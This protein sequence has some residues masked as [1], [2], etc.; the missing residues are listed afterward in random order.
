MTT[1]VN[2]QVQEQE[3]T[4][5][6]VA[7]GAKRWVLFEPEVSKKFVK[8]KDHKL[9]HEDDEAIDWFYNILPRIKNQIVLENLD[10]N[11]YEEVQNRGEVIF[12]PANWWHGVV[13]LEDSI[14]ITQNFAGYAEFDDVWKATRKQRK[15]LAS[16]WLRNLQRWRPECYERA[17]W[18]DKKFPL[19]DES[20]FD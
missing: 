4:K 2:Q 18:L 14:A 19:E 11:V 12:V 13:N 5:L 20:V 1:N 10:I 3:L 6:Q 9:K 7:T 8:G 17:R 16:R 15:M